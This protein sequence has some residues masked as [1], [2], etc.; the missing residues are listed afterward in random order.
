MLS[1]NFSLKHLSL[2]EKCLQ[3]KA[4]FSLD[5]PIFLAFPEEIWPP[6]RRP[7]LTLSSRGDWEVGEQLRF[8][9]VTSFWP[10]THLVL[11]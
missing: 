2:T 4:V 1:F 7:Q 8:E 9:S 6:R 5:I 11:H 10:F 3:R